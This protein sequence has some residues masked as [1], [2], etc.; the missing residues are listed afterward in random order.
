VWRARQFRVEPWPLVLATSI[1]AVLGSAL[2]GM[3]R[4][5]ADG[6]T[7]RY[8]YVVVVLLLPALALALQDV[9]TPLFRRHGKVLTYA[10]AVVLAG[11]LVVQVVGLNDEV[12]NEVFVGQMEPRTMV[13]AKLAHDNQP[14]IVTSLVPFT[15]EPTVQ[16]VTRLSR[17]GELPSLDGV[18]HEQVLSQAPWLQMTTDGAGTVKY[19]VAGGTCRTTSAAIDVPLTEASSLPV[20]SDRSGAIGIE[21][22]DAQGSGD[23]RQVNV[24][25]Q[26]T[27]VLNIARAPVTVRITPVPGGSLQVCGIPPAP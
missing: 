12:S 2:T 13:A 26:E 14:V 23:P 19:P 10:A 9:L 21:F 18:T 25:A 27:S 6:S 7:S 4:V 1:S 24:Q 15:Y 8:A 17:A 20:T 3:R 22:R 11:F 5:G 16:T